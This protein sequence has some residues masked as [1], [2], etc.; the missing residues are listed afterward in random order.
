M[1]DI[2]RAVFEHDYTDDELRASEEVAQKKKQAFAEY[3]KLVELQE[4]DCTPFGDV[5]LLTLDELRS[6]LEKT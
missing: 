3:C 2:L 6:K 4:Y 5:P 1:G